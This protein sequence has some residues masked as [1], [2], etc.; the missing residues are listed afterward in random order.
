M[1]PRNA[2]SKFAR[3][4]SHASVSFIAIS[5]QLINKRKLSL[6]YNTSRADF[7]RP[8]K[9]LGMRYGLSSTPKLSLSCVHA[10]AKRRITSS[11]G[12]SHLVKYVERYFPNTR[13]VFQVTRCNTAR[14]PCVTI[15]PSPRCIS[16]KTH[17]RFQFPT[18][19]W[20]QS[21]HAACPYDS[22]YIDPDEG[23]PQNVITARIVRKLV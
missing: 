20:M 5:P 17:R 16:A 11:H 9:N 6:S 13:R 12:E 10:P 3:Y 18:V 22:I 19:A 15:C 1:T 4:F 23:R 14:T 8:L 7:R 2:V 21:L